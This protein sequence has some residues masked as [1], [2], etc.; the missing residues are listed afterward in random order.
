M[1]AHQ[2]FKDHLVSSLHL[3]LPISTPAVVRESSF[4]RRT[5]SLLRYYEEGDSAALPGLWA[6]DLTRSPSSSCARAVSLD[7]PGASPA[8]TVKTV[9]FAHRGCS[10]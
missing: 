3:C 7:H 10:D 8:W 6:L 1:A 2:H 5:I 9:R 4:I